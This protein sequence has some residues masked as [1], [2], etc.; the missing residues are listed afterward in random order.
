MEMITDVSYV[1]WMYSASLS[2][3]LKRHIKE[4]VQ[5]HDS[6]YGDDH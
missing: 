4:I 1:D 6:Y 2:Q 3:G 5:Y